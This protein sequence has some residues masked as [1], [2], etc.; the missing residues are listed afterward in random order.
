MADETMDPTAKPS[1]ARVRSIA[2]HLKQMSDDDLQIFI[3]DAYQE[4]VDT[5]GAEPKYYER[6]SRW[7]AAH[8]ASLNERQANVERVGPIT[9]EYNLSRSGGETGANGI[10][11]TPYGLE[12]LRL[13]RRLTGRGRLN[14][15]VI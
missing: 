6:L 1:P 7:L 4:V 14:L 3:D 11:S 5:T 2:K 9:R 13:M 12:Y 10:Q 15:T 8:Y